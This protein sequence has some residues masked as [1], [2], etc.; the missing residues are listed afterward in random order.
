MAPARP[1]NG[2]P[3]ASSL[4]PGAS[5]TMT[6]G[7]VALPSPGTRFVACSQISKPHG[8]CPRI[9]AAIASSSLCALVVLTA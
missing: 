7:A 9:S 3:C 6:T 1:T 2:R 5:P 4:A 8:T